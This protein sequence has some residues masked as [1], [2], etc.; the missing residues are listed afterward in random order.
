MIL[1]SCQVPHIPEEELPSLM[2]DFEEIS[3]APVIQPISRQEVI[4]IARRYASHRW[5]ATNRNIWHGYDPENIRVDTPDAAFKEPSIRP[6][7][8]KVGEQNQGIAY[9]WGGFSTISEFDSGIING[10]AA[11]DILT[12]EKREM[13]AQGLPS[14]SRA[15]VGID[16]S[17]FV[18]RC[19]GLDRNHSTRELPE[20]CDTLA[21]FDELKPGDLI[22]LRGVHVILFEQ[23]ANERNKAVLVYEA[24][25]PPSWKVVYDHLPVSHLKRLGYK[26]L[27]FR[28]ITESP[29]YAR[30]L[31]LRSAIP[32]PPPPIALPEAMAPVPLPGVELLDD[33]DPT[34][35]FL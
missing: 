8:W 12:A 25:A 15:A 22:N 5:K 19:L 27:R 31:G 20:L 11:G 16:A 3:M 30:A 28:H 32:P 9:Q 6:G 14:V 23:F 7:W 18:S 13:L 17:G 26:P 1:S 33:A 10:L 24:G 29:D 21:S 35:P 2:G 4:K 34:A